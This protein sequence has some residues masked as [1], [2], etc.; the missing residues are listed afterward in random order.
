MFSPLFPHLRYFSSFSHMLFCTRVQHNNEQNTG[1]KSGYTFIPGLPIVRIQLAKRWADGG[2]FAMLVEILQRE[3][4][5]WPGG[6]HLLI[7]LKTLNISEVNNE[8][9]WLLYLFYFLIKL[10]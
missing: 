6:D 5:L 10:K 4:F 1:A 9:W 3:S 8:N 7:V 2:G